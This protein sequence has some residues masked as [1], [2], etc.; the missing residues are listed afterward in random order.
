MWPFH[1]HGL[2]RSTIRAAD[3]QTDDR[4]SPRDRAHAAQRALD[5]LGEQWNTS[6]TRNRLLLIGCLRQ[7]LRLA[8]DHH[9]ELDWLADAAWSYVSDSIGEP[10]APP[11]PHDPG[12]GL[13]TA[14]DALS[15]PSA[16]SAAGSTSTATAPSTAS[17]RS[18]TPTCCPPT[19]TSPALETAQT[20]GWAGRHHRVMGDVWWV[21]GDMTCPA[22]AYQAARGEAEQHGVAGERAACQAQCAFVLAFTDPEVADDELDLAEQLLAGLDLRAT[23]L[24]TQIAALLRD[25]L[26]ATV[27]RLREL[28]H[29]GDYTYYID[30][31]HFM[32]GLDL[33]PEPPHKHSGWTE[34][35]RP[36]T[37]GTLCSGHHPARTLAL[38]TVTADHLR[39]AAG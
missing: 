38:G 33:P 1:L 11:A 37:D 24:T 36:A 32:G 12:A 23:S 39:R 19:C 26:L 20:L 25:A 7:G 9:L 30:I 14:A 3:D 22:A 15:K 27:S 18:S 34:D 13:E 29:S 8:R 21:P 17:P 5:A 4:W 6:P 2:I 28:I 31:A 10:L 35:G 16:R